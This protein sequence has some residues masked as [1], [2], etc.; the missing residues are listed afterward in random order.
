M[1]TFVTTVIAVAL[2]STMSFAGIGE[3]VSNG[4]GKT[5]EVVE[6]QTGSSGNTRVVLL[7]DAGQERKFTVRKNGKVRG[8]GGKKLKANIA[9]MVAAD[10]A[11]K[12]AAVSA[13][14]T[15]SIQSAGKGHNLFTCELYNG[16]DRFFQMPHTVINK[17]IKAQ[18]DYADMMCAE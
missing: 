9:A 2:T 6:Q 7:N 18:N 5:L 12:A 15:A 1:K 10:A 13:P 4:Y 16:V 3:T 14:S 8:K 17:G 11:E